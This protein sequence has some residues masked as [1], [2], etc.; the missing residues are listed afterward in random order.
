MTDDEI[1]EMAREA[2]VPEWLFAMS[3]SAAMDAM[4]KFVEIVAARAA[5]EERDACAK[6][7]DAW[8][9]DEQRKFGDGGPAAAIRARGQEV[10]K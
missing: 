10:T 8:A 6:I 5:A 7:A 9:T 4:R 3:S 1:I 2:G